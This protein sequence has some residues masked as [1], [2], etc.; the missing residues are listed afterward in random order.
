MKAKDIL[1]DQSCWTQGAMARNRRGDLTGAEYVSAVSWC[2]MGALIRAYGRVKG[3]DR[4]MDVRRAI[5]GICKSFY[6]TYG[7]IESWNDE[8]GR[9]F[10]EVRQVIEK[11]DV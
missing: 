6:A 1:T 3:L 8:P 9:T 11:A 4:A 5:R 7:S 2:L 10:D